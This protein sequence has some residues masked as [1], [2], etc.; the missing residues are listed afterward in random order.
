MLLIFLA[1]VGS[2]VVYN[3]VR[4]WRAAVYCLPVVTGGD[5]SEAPVYS[6]SGLKLED[7]N[8]Q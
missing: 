3:A 8:P 7:I 5:M 1:K 2:R 4:V 6:S